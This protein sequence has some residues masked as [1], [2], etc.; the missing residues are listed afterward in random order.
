VATAAVVATTQASQLF[1][2]MRHGVL[3]GG[4][5]R[6]TNADAVTGGSRRWG[7]HHKTFGRQIRGCEDDRNGEG[8]SS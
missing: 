4:A 6:Q 1:G 2:S 3:S 5:G 8:S 7:L